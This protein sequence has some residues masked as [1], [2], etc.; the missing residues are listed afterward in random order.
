[1]SQDG[2]AADDIPGTAAAT[3]IL[4]AEQIGGDPLHLLIQRTAKMRFAPNALVFP[5]GQVDVDDYRIAAD[6]VLLDVGFGDATER[7]HRVAAIRETLEETG[8]A[9][10]LVL[11]ARFDAA[12]MQAELKR[13]VAFSD[14]L[15]AANVRLDLSMLLPWAQWHPR[16]SRRRFDTRFYIA[17]HKGSLT[18]RT[19]VDEVGDARWLTAGQAIAE[20]ES[21]RAKVIFPTLCNLERLAEY[22]DFLAAAAH[23]TTVECRPISPWLHDDERGVPSISIPEGSGYPT[24]CRPLATLQAP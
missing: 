10:G 22:P 9:A 5:G 18:V 16:L 2:D 3:M 24:T 23:L 20:A 4:F 17:R 11:P 15:K 6:P 7:A 19:D 14:L 13:Q 8:V 12:G 1:M 21:G